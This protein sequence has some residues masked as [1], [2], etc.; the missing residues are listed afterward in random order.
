MHDPRMA[1]KIHHKPI[2]LCF[3]FVEFILHV[4]H[5]TYNDSS[6]VEKSHDKSRAHKCFFY[7][8]AIYWFWYINDMTKLEENSK[9]NFQIH[10]YNTHGT[11]YTVHN[12]HGTCMNENVFV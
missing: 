10:I 1:Y 6:E 11:R 8:N 5:F 4:I 2:P 3:H 9:I 12:T 7:R